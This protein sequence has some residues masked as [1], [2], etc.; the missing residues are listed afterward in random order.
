MT[1]GGRG[2]L[3]VLWI[4]ST[5]TGERRQLTTADAVQPAWS[6]HG[7]R[8]AYWGLLSD[9]SQRDLW[10]IAAEGG[11]PVRVT[12]DPA[13]DW[14]P[15]WSPDGRYLNFSSDRSGGFNLWRVAIDEASGRTAGEPTPVP[16]PRSAIG[17]LSFNA[18]GTMLAMTSFSAQ[19]SIEALA[20]DPVRGTV[21]ARRKV[22]NTSETPSFPSVSP[23]GQW[24]AFH[25][26]LTNG[27]E[28]LWVVRRDGTGL[29]QLTNDAAHDRRPSWSNDGNRL[30]FYSD[31]SGRYQVWTIAADGGGLTQVTDFPGTVTE[32]V[33][34]R[35]ETRAVANVSRASKVLMFDPRIPASQQNIE[36]LPPFSSGGFRATAWSPDGKQIAGGVNRSSGGTVIYTVASR[37]YEQI[38]PSGIGATWLPDGRRMLYVDAG[39][40]AVVDT[41][42][43]VITPVFSS[44]G[45]TLSTPGLSADAR[46]IYVV[47]T[48]R[49]AE[50]VLAKLT[51]G[52]P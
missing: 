18:D 21:G 7:Q 29:R 15:A 4:V 11:E 50:I 20:F 37:T 27:R 41:T 34:S 49:Q 39:R 36:E 6:P 16:V 22:T 1:P 23:D 9:S 5:T 24:V 8:I 38:T 44:L 45:E 30:M 32:P 26:Q 25:Q 35:D 28:D 47:I 31:R 40:L 3:S 33:R 51:G 46:E 13:I 10:T 42:T 12:N 2:S 14:S 52:A 43:K 48:K 17:H 19:S